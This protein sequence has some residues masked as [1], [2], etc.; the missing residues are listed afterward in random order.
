ME[1]ISYI[2]CPSCGAR[3]IQLDNLE[4]KCPSCKNQYSKEEAEGS[5]A[6]NYEKKLREAILTTKGEISAMVDD[7]LKEA[8]DEKAAHCRQMLWNSMNDEFINSAKVV[9]CARALKEY[10]PDD[11]FA[12]FCEVANSGND[13]E[14]NAFL[15]NTTKEQMKEYADIV[16]EF[17][18]KS[19][20]PANLTS[21]SMFIERAYKGVDTK[22][23]DKYMTQYED[24]AENVTHGLYE[25]TITRDVFLAY[26]SKDIDRVIELCD[27]LEEQ[28]ITCFMAL[29][30]LRHGR[31]AVDN[32]EQ[33]LKTAIDNCKTVVFVSSTNSRDLKCDA[34]TKELPY[35][36]AKDLENAPEYKRDYS[37]MPFED[38]I[39][40]V[41]YL[42][43]GYIDNP[44]ASLVEGIAKEFFHGLE[45]CNSKEA[46]AERVSKYI[47]EVRETTAQKTARQAQEY[48]QQIE[49]MQRQISEVQKKAAELNSSS[50]DSNGISNAQI[51]AWLIRAEQESE[52]GLTSSARNYYNKVKD[53]APDNYE[54]WLGLFYLLNET[55]K[56]AGIKVCEDCSDLKEAKRRIEQNMKTLSTF[57]SYEFN[58]AL[59]YAPDKEAEELKKFKEE[60]CQ[61]INEVNSGI[62]NRLFILAEE[63]SKTDV[64]TAKQEYEFIIKIVPANSKAW[65]GL[66]YLLNN[67][68]KKPGLKSKVGLKIFGNCND[69]EEAKVCWNTNKYTLSTF[70]SDEFSNALKYATSDSIEGVKK[71]KDETCQEIEKCNGMIADKLFSIAEGH[72]KSDHE[73]AKKEYEFIIQMDNN[74]FDAYK[75]LLFLEVAAPDM[76]CL[77]AKLNDKTLNKL[78]ESEIYREIHKVAKGEFKEEIESLDEAIRKKVDYIEETQNKKVTEMQNTLQATKDEQEKNITPYRTKMENL[79]ILCNKYK[80]YDFSTSSVG[81]TVAA[82]I[83]FGFVFLLTLCINLI[84]LSYFVY[85]Y[86]AVGLD[87]IDIIFDSATDYAKVIISVVAMLVCGTSFV[88][89]IKKLKRM[90]AQKKANLKHNVAEKEYKTLVNK[91]NDKNA[92]LESELKQ[93]Q[94]EYSEVAKLK[95]YFDNLAFNSEVTI[96]Y[97]L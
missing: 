36:K 71:L 7:A 78:M 58:N 35:I 93:A 1:K 53:V 17:M 75:G 79:E 94:E 76:A 3:L 70:E 39:P 62:L 95:N 91:N 68:S 12:N 73:L 49:E 22:S 81:G 42:I 43:E 60:T 47:I 8:N 25:L 44:S 34:L 10:L 21:I 90:K 89:S 19:A 82:I 15:N 59:R 88:N 92:K 26:S 41:E 33:A 69:L 96:A 20:R 9:S 83:I 46:V 37:Q 50:Q 23:Y 77:K 74:Y 54:A 85:E 67:T 18:I 29:R 11:Y 61:K 5:L 14:V 52:Q 38:M 72:S 45:W 87:C 51:H 65:L 4:Y 80:K 16:I 32:Y 40:R 30:N 31:G 63:H 6:A 57:E 97:S 48:Q 86:M 55:T 66:F 27:Y 2:K 84:F 13:K 28:G 24:E 56:R 64:T